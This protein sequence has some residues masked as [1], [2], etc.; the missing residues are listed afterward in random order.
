MIVSIRLL[1]ALEMTPLKAAPYS[2]GVVKKLKRTILTNHSSEST[3]ENA[4]VERALLR[5]LLAGR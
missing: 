2:P 5:T 4:W 1:S 3:A